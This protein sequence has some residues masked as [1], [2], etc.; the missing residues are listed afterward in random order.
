MPR[1]LTYRT[2]AGGISRRDDLS[3]RHCLAVGRTAILSPLPPHPGR[4]QGKEPDGPAPARPRRAS[5]GALPPP[6]APSGPASLA[7]PVGGRGQLP[8]LAGHSPAGA[9][10]ALGR[11]PAARRRRGGDRG[12]P[13]PNSPRGAASAPAA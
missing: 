2:L 6:P 9:P 4:V 13:L 10:A 11:G 3:R 1:G 7:A 12:Q 5:A 8:A